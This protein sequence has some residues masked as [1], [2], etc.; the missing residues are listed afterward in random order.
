MVLARR[1]GRKPAPAATTARIVSA[2]AAEAI[3]VALTPNNCVE[4]YLL[5][6]SAAGMPMARP[7]ATSTMVS[8]MTIHTTCPRGAPSAMRRVREATATKVNNGLRV[9]LRRANRRSNRNLAMPYQL[10]TPHG[11]KGLQKIVG[12]AGV[13]S[14]AACLFSPD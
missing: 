6:A 13:P 14:G 7:A 3:S 4:T 11:G 8:R 10:D 5:T 12:Q 1:A 2:A 9:R